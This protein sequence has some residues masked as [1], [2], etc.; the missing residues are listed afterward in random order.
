M[1]VLVASDWREPRRRPER[2]AIEER[3]EG[4]RQDGPPFLRA[5]QLLRTF[6]QAS[7][8][9]GCSRERPGG[10][11]CFGVR[12]R[13]ADRRLPRVPRA[14][15]D[16]RQKQGPVALA[17]AKLIYCPPALHGARAT[18]KFS[19]VIPSR[20]PKPKRRDRLSRDHVAEGMLAVAVPRRAGDHHERQEVLLA[21]VTRAGGGG[22]LSQS[23]SRA[24]R[25]SRGA[26]TVSS[27]QASKVAEAPWPPCAQTLPKTA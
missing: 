2:A 26:L 16:G 17:I 14:R 27:S 15:R 20:S 6:G 21:R 8:E 23:A 12:T 24:S 10:G 9:D 13:H 22:A 7:Q 19:E 18:S 5:R 3:L 1:H 11:L 25:S 4:A